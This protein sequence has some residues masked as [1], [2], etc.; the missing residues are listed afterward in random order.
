MATCPV[1]QRASWWD[2]L[3]Y[4]YLLR[5]QF[6]TMLVLVVGPFAAVH[7]APALLRGVF[8][9][10]GRGMA[11]IALAAALA[12][13]T[14]MLTT[15]QVLLYGP[16]RF[17]VR[18]FPLKAK[19]LHTVPGNGG[20]WLA[21][22][23]MAA[24]TIAETA[25]VSKNGGT[26]TYAELAGGAA[27][28]ILIAWGVVWIAAKLR[29]QSW[30]EARWV[31]WFLSAFGP[32]FRASAGTAYKGHY[33]A[34]WSF[35]LCLGFYAGIG[36]GKYVRIGNNHATVPTLADL[37]V[38]LMILCWSL[39]AIA[40]FLDR[41]RI[42]LLVPFLLFA[43]VTS[44]L[45]ET[46]HFFAVQENKAMYSDFDPASVIR[47]GK[48]GS[49]VIV[50]A[51][52]GGGIKAA[53]WTAQVLVGLEL[54]SQKDFEPANP[55]DFADS[56]RLIS[57]VSG[58]SVGA[59]YFVDDY[60]TNGYELPKKNAYD[61]V[62]KS[63]Q[64]SLD[65]IAW[66]LVYPD[67]LRV[68]SGFGGQLDRGLAL[69]RAF[70]QRRK[71]ADKMLSDWRAGVKEGW[72][73]SVVFNATVTETGER[74]LMGTTDLAC[75]KGRQRLIDPPFQNMDVAVATAVRLSATFP[76]VS[77]AAR[78]SSMDATNAITATSA[79]NG[80]GE[81]T[82]NP[83]HVVDGGY[84]D[85]FGMA[86]L[87]AW[88]DEALQSE[89]SSIH[90]LLIVEIRASPE[91]DGAAVKKRGWAFQ[92]YAPLSA[93]LDVRDTGQLPRNTEERELLRRAYPKTV[94]T[95]AIFTYNSTDAPLSWHFSQNDKDEIGKTWSDGTKEPCNQE[96]R[97][98]VLRFLHGEDTPN[99]PAHDC[100]Q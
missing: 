87:L 24:P 64:S 19:D 96:S 52:S 1:I 77:P 88:L 42:P 91:S 90:R 61:A 92:T 85:N 26:A 53:A 65:E 63:E 10:T 56:I 38:Y 30:S 49:N 54:D 7:F 23:V 84:T 78:A 57:A 58:G 94:M 34:F 35:L 32:G 80:C 81:P 45:P 21:F 50:V 8:D 83:V 98:R 13:W 33:T 27:A 70:E 41:F 29:K 37:L 68:V 31:S 48:A 40:F 5:V 14:V 2:A 4:L 100:P 46:D 36:V 93:M 95:D 74:L 51:A 15:W 72:R 73:P 3:P 99:M 76:Y 86:T 43:T 25:C 55:A 89:S 75:Q 6:L 47:D 69:E 44:N 16:E 59:M 17:H 79:T 67:F 97:R 62:D 66:G 20:H 28:G 39:A 82:A 71:K 18:P 12:S 22:I 11:F 60:Q 9:V